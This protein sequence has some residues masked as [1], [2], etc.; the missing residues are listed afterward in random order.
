MI[1]VQTPI[2]QSGDSLTMAVSDS[3]FTCFDVG[4][5]FNSDPEIIRQQADGKILVGGYYT[6]YNGVSANRIVR[7]NTDF[8]ID[9][10]FVYG[11]GF[12]GDTTGLVIQSDGKIV[13]GGTFTSYNGTSRNR[14]IRLNTDGSVDTTFSVGTGFDAA[15]WAITLQPDGKILVGGDFTSYSGSSRSKIIR[16]NTNG[17]IDTTFVSPGTINSTIYDIG[18]QPDN[19]VVVVGSFTS[20]SAVTNNRIA[21]FSSTGV[22]DNTFITGGLNGFGAFVVLCQTDGK[23]VVGGDFSQVSGVSSSGIVRLLSGGTIDATFNVGSG[24]TQSGGNLQILDITLTNGKYLV[25]GQFGSY[26]GTTA[27]ALARIDSNGTL[28]TT[29]NQ[30]AGFTYNISGFSLPSIPLADGNI[31]VGGDLSA[32]DG[33]STPKITVLTPFGKINVTKPLSQQ[34]SP[35]IKE[36][37]IVGLGLIDPAKDNTLHH[38]AVLFNRTLHVEAGPRFAP[39]RRLGSHQ[40]FEGPA[41]GAEGVARLV[42]VRLLD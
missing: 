22:I 11:T 29:L 37:Q 17:T 34:F 28:D 1:S 10:T 24:F 15:V 2:L 9:D 18:V 19:K 4:T 25:S 42:G 36:P 32:Y 41:S 40:L 26:N 20:I 31:V 8:S 6:T 23:V 13:V 14:I 7:L 16:L 33:V 27:K 3:Q 39:D 21:R 38:P 12:N 30:G 5:G 35:G